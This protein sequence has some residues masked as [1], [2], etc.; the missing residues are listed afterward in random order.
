MV[1]GY[2]VPV[3]KFMPECPK[4]SSVACDGLGF[5]GNSSVRPS[6]SNVIRNARIINRNY[7]KIESI[8]N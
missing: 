2:V 5:S 8:C 3:D 7:V 1:D 4:V 6:R